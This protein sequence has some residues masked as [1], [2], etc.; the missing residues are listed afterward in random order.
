MKLFSQPS[1]C[2][3]RAPGTYRGL[4]W[5]LSLPRQGTEP[6]FVT[7]FTPGT[8]VIAG[9]SLSEHLPF[10]RKPGLCGHLGLGVCRFL[11]LLV[12]LCSSPG[13]QFCTRFVSTELL[14]PDPRF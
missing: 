11:Y 2:Q 1:D 6:V 14:L 13:S 10:Q 9:S 7:M 5:V 4:S 3:S 12:G 8:P